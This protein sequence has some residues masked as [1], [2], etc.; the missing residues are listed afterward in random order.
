MD[1]RSGNLLKGS[2]NRLKSRDELPLVH[3]AFCTGA[4]SNE[5][6]G[7]VIFVFPE[8]PL[9]V[10]Q[11]ATEDNRGGVRDCSR[12]LCHGCYLLFVCTVNI[13]RLKLDY[14]GF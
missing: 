11:T 10:R 3:A 12:H 4:W 1:F 6:D 7:F 9:G 14:D 5:A 13:D 8:G 2:S